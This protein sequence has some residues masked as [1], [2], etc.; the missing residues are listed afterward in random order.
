MLNARLLSPEE[1]GGRYTV[2]GDPTEACLLVAA[3]KAGIE[4]SEQEA[5]WPRVRELPF[6][7]AASA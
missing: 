4:P 5:A 2:L 6:E 3:Q 1:E 7:S